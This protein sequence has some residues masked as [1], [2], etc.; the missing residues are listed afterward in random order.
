LLGS[1]DPQQAPLVRRKIL[2]LKGAKLLDVST[3]DTAEAAAADRFSNRIVQAFYPEMFQ[4]LGYPMRVK[5][6]GQLWR[7]IDVMHE[8]RT[9]HNIDYLLQGMT[10]E[11]FELYKRVVK[12]VDEHARK[13]FDMR[14]HPTAALL[15][16][17]H[18][19]RL[20]KIVTGDG[21]PTVLEV[22][23]GSGYLAM[24]LVMEGY[25]YIGTEVVQAFYFYQNHMLSQVAT[26]LRELVAEDGDILTV[27]QP[28]PGTAIHIPWWKWITLSPEKINLSAGIMTS[29]HVM[30]E[31]HPSSMAYMA[32]VGRQMLSRHPGGGRFVFENWG[33]DLL[34]SPKVVADKFAEHGLIVCHDE[35]AMSAMVLSEEIDRWL[36]RPQAAS[37]LEGSPA[38]KLGGDATGWRAVR[39]RVGTS[40]DTVPPLKRLAVV[41]YAQLLKLRMQGPAA[42]VKGPHGAHPLSKQL[43]EGRAAVI[44]RAT[45]REPDIQAFLVSYFG[46]AVPQL[47]D[48]AFFALIGTR[49]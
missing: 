24:L 40:L 21:R 11:E 10:E 46:D 31:M 26:H 3:Y 4:T 19:L 13:N 16:A 38:A 17:I 9:R 12:I 48:E 8:T 30:C 23:P 27:E 37:R 6:D 36:G 32:V 28:K 42:V 45:I 39:R 15:R 49:Q 33:Y 35:Y 1:A 43:T 22:G 29:N 20:I 44:A 14:A 25:P 18:V 2:G 41:A 34:H 47:P 5:R 7:Y